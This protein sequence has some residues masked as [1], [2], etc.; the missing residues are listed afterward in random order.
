MNEYPN[1]CVA[2]KSIEYF[3]KR[4]FLLLNILTYSNI[5]K[6]ATHSFRITGLSLA[7]NCYFSRDWTARLIFNECSEPSISPPL[8]S[9]YFCTFQLHDFN[10]DFRASHATVL[11]DNINK[12]SFVSVCI[13]F[14]VL[15][16]GEVK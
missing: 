10:H 13:F 8:V 5:K 11:K 1:T 7:K 12:L 3:D 15:N 9:L 4:I 16:N 2:L 6:N 14:Y